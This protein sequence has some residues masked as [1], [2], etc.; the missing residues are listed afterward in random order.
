MEDLLYIKQNNIWFVGQAKQD[1]LKMSNVYFF[2]FFF[3]N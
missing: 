2:F 3:L 1:N